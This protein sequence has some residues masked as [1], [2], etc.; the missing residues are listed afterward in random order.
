[1]KAIQNKIYLYFTSESFNSLRARGT[2][3]RG[4]WTYVYHNLNQT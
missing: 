1:M 4:C 2:A 3:N